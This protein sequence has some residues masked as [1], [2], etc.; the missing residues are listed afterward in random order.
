MISLWLKHF[1]FIPLLAAACFCYTP[2]QAETLATPSTATIYIDGRVTHFTAYNINGENYFKIRDIAN[3]VN[4]TKSCFNVEWYEEQ[5][6]IVLKSGESYIPTGQEMQ[7]SFD[8]EPKPIQKSESKV[9]LNDSQIDIKSYRI[10]DNTYY[11]LRDIAEQFHFLVD[12]DDCLQTIFI[13]TNT[14]SSKPE[15]NLNAQEIYDKCSPSV[16]YIETYDM[17]GIPFGSGSGFFID[18]NG[19]AVTNLHVLEDALSA[20]VVLTDARELPV[21]KVIGYN[22][23][24]DIAIIQIEGEDFPGLELRNSSTIKGG[25]KIYTLGSPMG[26]SNTISEGIVSN[27]VRE[28]EGSRYIQISAPISNG[29]S[30][31]ALLDS[32]GKVIGVTTAENPYGQNLNFATPA[33]FIQDTLDENKETLSF[34]EFAAQRTIENYQSIQ[35]FDIIVQEKEPND[36]P[37]QAQFLYNGSSVIGTIN[38]KYSDWYFS[39]CYLPGT[40]KLYCYTEPDVLD[41]L[42]LRVMDDTGRSVE[43]TRYNLDN[44]TRG[45]YVEYRVREA[46]YI[47]IELQAKKEKLEKNIDYTFYY[48]FVPENADKGAR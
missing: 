36:I 44:H 3:S 39:A 35:A 26:L 20:K 42:L 38:D 15:M 24:K 4:H 23:D 37:Q 48:E 9:F 16:F 22:V 41:N 40:V 18:T 43:A 2:V 10:E 46:S 28:I 13:Q 7:V 11:R 5:N 14:Q 17:N 34:Q 25:E 29:S 31:G 12:W 47:N 30:G 8:K 21:K 19:T 33:D 32:Y 45:L 27:P 6:T 1:T